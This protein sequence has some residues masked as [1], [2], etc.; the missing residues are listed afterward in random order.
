MAITGEHR[1]DISAATSGLLGAQI[2]YERAK[3]DL[4]NTKLFSPMNC[5][6]LQPL[7]LLLINMVWVWLR[8]MSIL[9]VNPNSPMALQA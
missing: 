8:S 2:S 5:K 4:E 6:M 9:K 3:L 7:K 1:G